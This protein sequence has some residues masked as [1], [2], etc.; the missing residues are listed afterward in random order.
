MKWMVTISALPSRSETLQVEAKSSLDALRE[1]LSREMVAE[2]L[3]RQS[4]AS[5]CISVMKPVRGEK[6]TDAAQRVPTTGGLDLR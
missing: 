5:L 4:G 6:T 2:A 1:V 3:E